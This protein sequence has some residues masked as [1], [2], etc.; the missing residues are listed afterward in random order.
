MTVPK[1]HGE[2]RTNVCAI[3]YDENG[4]RVARPVCPAEEEIIQKF[5][6][7]DF[8]VQN[9][10]FATGL[11]NPCRID[12]WKLNR[13]VIKSIFVSQNFGAAVPVNLRSGK[14]QC[15]ICDIGRKAGRT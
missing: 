10:K 15:V 2:H 13:K 1:S 7:R 11:C 5:I 3:C 6:S 4:K 12:L 8:S 14:C 9:E